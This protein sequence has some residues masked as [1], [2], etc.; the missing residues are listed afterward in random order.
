MSLCPWL[1]GS[2]TAQLHGHDFA[3]LAQGVGEWDSLDP[4]PVLSLNNPLRR[5]VALLEATGYLVIA[6]RTDNPGVWLMH[7]HIGS[8]PPY[9]VRKRD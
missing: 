3:I 5:D 7:C 1:I 9:S 2:N 8:P 4:K 6:F